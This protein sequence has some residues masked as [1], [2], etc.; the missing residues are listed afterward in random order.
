MRAHC[1][2]DP[3]TQV[4]LIAIAEWRLSCSCQGFN[5]T[6]GRNASPASQFGTARAVTAA[7]IE[8]GFRL[9]QEI[10]CI[11]VATVVVSGSALG[12]SQS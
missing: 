1:L 12:R 3:A 7:D 5:A 8:I 2:L 9:A 6:S 11:I 10:F 4:A